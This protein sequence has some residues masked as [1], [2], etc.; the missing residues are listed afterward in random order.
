MSTIK[1]VMTKNVV[2]LKANNTVLDAAKLMKERSLG[3]IVVVDGDDPLGIVTERDFVR[4]VIAETLPV[5]TE[6]LEVMSKPI[7]VIDAN[8]SVREAAR[9]M[10]D[11]KIRRLPVV[12]EEKLVGI[13]VASD[14]VRHMSRKPFTEKLSELILDALS[15][16]P[17]DYPDY[18]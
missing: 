13:V 17:P 4:R 9:I 8:A 15:R 11:N 18:V 5:T 14:L 6:I 10:R 1:D 2:T 3:C 7:M 16:Y 12:E